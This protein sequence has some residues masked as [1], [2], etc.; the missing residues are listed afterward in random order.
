VR[1][2]AV[3]VT[4]NRRELLTEC[5]EALAR[6]TRPVDEVL[7]VDNASTDGSREHV[8]ASGVDGRLPLRWVRLER[9]GGGAEGFHHG[10]RLA[11]QGE[12]D[13]LWLMD[14]DCLAADDALERLLASARVDEATVL[15][16]VVREPGG[17]LLPVNRGHVRPRWGFAPLVAASE[18]EYARDEVEIDFCSFVG[19]LVR[20]DAARG[21]DPPLREMFIRFEDVEYLQRLG[22]PMWMV[23]AAVMLHAD[24]RPLIGADLRAHW[25]D[26]SQR[27]PFDQQWKRLYGFRN[28]LYAGRTGGYLSA[29][30]ALAQFAVQAVRTLLFHERRARTLLLLA[31]YGLDGWRGRFRNVPPE[32]WAGVARARRP[33]AYVNREALRYDGA[34]P[35]A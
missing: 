25:G 2:V 33:L 4:Y 29:G 6:Q 10:V 17:R 8:E 32:R 16:P 20:A 27:V 30:Q 23:S 26:Y 5:L 22:G 11:L 18:E 7:V 12:A 21:I 28:L 3:V 35:P 31:A 9:N 1:V 24:P 14:D 19:P 34:T 15:A 13:W